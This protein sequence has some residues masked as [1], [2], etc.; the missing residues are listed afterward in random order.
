MHDDFSDPDAPQRVDMSSYLIAVH[1][2]P[3]FNP[4][5]NWSRPRSLKRFKVEPFGDDDQP[6]TV[7]QGVV[8]PTWWL[9]ALLLPTMLWL[10]FAI[11]HRVQR[12]MMRRHAT[13]AGFEVVRAQ[14]LHS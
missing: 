1:F 4:V 6:H 3:W 10:A 9:I 7:G 11:A 2:H 14:Q 13:W 12:W 5:G 8:F